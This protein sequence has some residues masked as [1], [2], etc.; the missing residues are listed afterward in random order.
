MAKTIIKT[1][2]I[3]CTKPDIESP[4]PI[5]YTKCHTLNHL[6][7]KLKPKVHRNPTINP[8]D[9]IEQNAKFFLDIVKPQT[10]MHLLEP[11]PKQTPTN[12]K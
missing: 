5:H 7:Y 4:R 10:K 11:N 1:L 12:D 8:K 3:K 9:V 2:T 6:H